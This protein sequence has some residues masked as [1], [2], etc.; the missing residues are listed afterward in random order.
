MQSPEDRE[1][2]ERV[3]RATALAETVFESP[4]AAHGFLTSPHPLLDGAVPIELAT[5]AE[6]GACRV[7]ALLRRLQHSLPV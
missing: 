1:R 7:E 5:A 4:A 6:P 2:Q 3:A